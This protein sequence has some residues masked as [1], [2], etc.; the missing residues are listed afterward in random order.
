MVRPNDVIHGIER[1]LVPRS[2]QEDFNW[3]RSLAAI[4]AVLLIGAPEV[5]PRTHQLKKLIE[6]GTVCDDGDNCCQDDSQRWRR[7]T[8]SPLRTQGFISFWV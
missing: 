1:L 2:V 4:S 7:C 8:P 3:R 6:G 5:D